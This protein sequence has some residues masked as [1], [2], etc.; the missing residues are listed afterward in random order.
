MNGFLATLDNNATPP[1]NG[2]STTGNVLWPSPFLVQAYTQAE[3][4][5]QTRLF[6]DCPTRF[7]RFAKAIQLLWLVEDSVLADSI[8]AADP[9]IT[10]RAQLVGQLTGVATAYLHAVNDALA[11]LPTMQSDVL[12]PDLREVWENTVTPADRLAAFVVHF[13]RMHD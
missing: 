11:Q 4:E 1:V 2:L 5:V 13:G 12:E 3:A 10:Y 9:S 6:G 8:A 7:S